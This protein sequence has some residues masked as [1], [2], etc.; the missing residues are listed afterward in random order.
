MQLQ[1]TIIPNQS[2]SA[3][4]LDLRHN[5]NWSITGVYGPQGEFEKK[6]FL[7]ELHSLKNSMLENG[8]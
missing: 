6:M 4:V 1:N 5:T 8:C 3:Y 2:I 7:R